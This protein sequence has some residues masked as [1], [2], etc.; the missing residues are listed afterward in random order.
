V[1][2][3]DF[4][5]FIWQEMAWQPMIPSIE[6]KKSLDDKGC[7]YRDKKCLDRNRKREEEDFASYGHPCLNE[8]SL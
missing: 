1:G 5:R 2:L 8:H 3:S 4:L 7:D 6:L